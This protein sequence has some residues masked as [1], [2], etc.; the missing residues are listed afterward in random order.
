MYKKGMSEGKNRWGKLVDKQLHRIAIGMSYA[1]SGSCLALDSRTVPTQGRN[2]TRGHGAWPGTDGVLSIMVVIRHTCRWPVV[3]WPL[4][5]SWPGHVTSRSV[6]QQCVIQPRVLSRATVAGKT[7]S[8]LQLLFVQCACVQLSVQNRAFACNS[9]LHPC[10]I[11]KATCSMPDY[12]GNR[13][14]KYKTHRKKIRES[15]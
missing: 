6:A 10:V 13:I 11:R 12:Q 4:H 1:T 3:T 2:S 14:N 15:S 8:I 7:D 9:R 5:V